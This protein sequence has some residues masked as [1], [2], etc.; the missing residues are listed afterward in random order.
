MLLLLIVQ[1]TKG[2]S[3]EHSNPFFKKEVS[4]FKENAKFLYIS[5]LFIV[6]GSKISLKCPKMKKSHKPFYLRLS[7]HYFDY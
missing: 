7:K 3:T 5:Y 4:A 1:I 2:C 6:L